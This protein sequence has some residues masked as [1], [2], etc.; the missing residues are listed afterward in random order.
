MRAV[1][2]IIR[3]RNRDILDA[4]DIESFIQGVVEGSI[5]EY[6]AAAWLMAAYLNGLN[7]DETAALTRAM[8]TS[9]D[10]FDLSAIPGVTVDKHSTGGVGDKVSLILAPLAASAGVPVPMVSGRSLGHTGGTLDKLETIPG[11]SNS[12]SGYN[13]Y[14]TGEQFARQVAEIGCAIIGQTDNFVPADKILYALRDVTGTVESIPLITA[15]ILSK[16]FASGADAF[17]MDV[18]TGSGAFMKTPEQ[19]REL[20]E[21]MR[22]IGDR[23]G[24]RIVCLL[25]DM[26]QPL[27]RWVG[28]RAEVR[29]SIDVLRGGGDERLRELTV[30]LAAWMMRLAGAETDLEQARQSLD[31]NLKNGRALSKFKKMV[32]AQG[33]DPRIADDP[34]LL[35]LTE[36]RYDVVADRSGSLAAYDT[37]AVGVASMLLG[38]GRQKAS[39]TIDPAVAIEVHKQ[40]GDPVQAGE[41]ILTLYYNDEAKRAAAR[42]AL[43]NAIRLED[44]PVAPPPL[45]REVIGDGDATDQ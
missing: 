16:K 35:P 40:I 24:K 29:E 38:A 5:P 1:D 23:V 22:R 20:A 7:F 27:G 19:A 44:A 3:K 26:D 39:D 21:T 32:A 31:A 30:T 43:A 33:G 9:G 36:N 41:P 28:N 25:T 34:G 10:Q 14:L 15:S 37:Y 45:V 8:M 12:K 13:P 6:Q 2:C 17:V 4:A 18:K 11:P 42:E